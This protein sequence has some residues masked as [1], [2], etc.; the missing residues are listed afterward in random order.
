[1]QAL[2]RSLRSLKYSLAVLVALGACAP[3]SESHSQEEENSQEERSN[4]LVQLTQICSGQNAVTKKK[5]EKIHFFYENSG[6]MRGYEKSGSAFR[7]RIYDLLNNIQN[8]FRQSLNGYFVNSALHPVQNLR[9][10]FKQ[11]NVVEGD[12][13]S[14][15]HDSIYTWALRKANDGAVSIVVTDGIYS[16]KNFDGSTLDFL[17][18][19]IRNIFKNFTR[20]TEVIIYKYT[21]RFDGRYYR[22]KALCGANAAVNLKG[23]R[24]YYIILFGPRKEVNHIDAN[25]FPTSEQTDFVNKAHFYSY[26]PEVPFTLLEESDDKVGKYKGTGVW[27]HN[28]LKVKGIDILPGGKGNGIMFD[29]AV[30]LGAI[31]TSVEILQNSRN[32][33]LSSD[34]LRVVKVKPIEK[35]GAITGSQLKTIKQTENKCFTHVLTIAGLPSDD[36]KVQLYMKENLPGW[37]EASQINDDCDI[38]NHPQSTYTFFEVVSGISQ[39]YQETQGYQEN[40]VQFN[41]NLTL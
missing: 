30:N 21:S 27:I 15:A 11:G 25:Y 24:P 9:D 17:Q 37:I 41:F 19:D 32:Y 39:A 23:D 34:R 4:D 20:N 10:R 3:D 35:V 13:T 2:K 36:P 29:I 14:S 5:P 31:R 22:N 28:T 12:I 7:S 6:S 33:G 26:R 8:D 40:T 16:S 18:S 38:A 1:M